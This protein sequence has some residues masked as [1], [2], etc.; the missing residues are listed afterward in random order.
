MLTGEEEI[1]QAVR[2]KRGGMKTCVKRLL[3]SIC[4][5]PVAAATALAA[6]NIVQVFSFDFGAAPSTHIDPTVNLGDT[7]EWE[8]V[9]TD[10]MAHSTTAAA[11]QPENWD[12]GVHSTPFAFNH[13]F[14]QL[15]TFNYYCTVHGFDSGGGQVGGMSGHIHVVMPVPDVRTYLAAGKGQHFDQTDASTLTMADPGFMFTATVRGVATNTVL[16]ATDQPPGSTTKV[17]AKESPGSDTFEFQES[18]TSKPAFDAA[19][20]NGTYAMTIAT[21]DDGTLTPSLTLPGDAYP[22]TPQIVNFAAAQTVGASSNF[23]VMWNPF[24]SGTSNDVVRFEIDDPSGLT[25]TSSPEFGDVGQL[26]GTATSFV[27]AAGTLAPNA[28]YTGTVEFVKI[29]TRDTN[30]V[31][32]AIGITAYMETTR[33]PLATFPPPIGSCSLVPVLATNNV[34]ATHT[35]TSTITT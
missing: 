23:V 31:P 2:T 6:T 30:S 18:F 22:N 19:Y 1:S 29:T 15:G 10:G 12:S 3:A 21:A 32:G 33:F 35:V 28:A 34:G 11:G 7:V 5:L 14:T 20:T 17:L 13:T 9:N 16:S 4:F 25:V 8:W 26:D 27:I 24:S